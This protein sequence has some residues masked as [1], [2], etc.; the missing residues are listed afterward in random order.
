[1]DNKGFTLVELLVAAFLL[2][3]LV[4]CW[5][6]YWNLPEQIAMQL[7]VKQMHCSTG[8]LPWRKLSMN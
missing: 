4:F 6:L 2:V 8:A 7:P 1:M 5:Q 3:T